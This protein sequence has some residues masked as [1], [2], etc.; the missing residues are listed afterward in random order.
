MVKHL[1]MVQNKTK[2]QQKFLKLKK[3]KLQG[4]R[5]RQQQAGNLKRK[6]DSRKQQSSNRTTSTSHHHKSCHVTKPQPDCVQCT[7]R[8]RVLRGGRAALFTSGA[9]RHAAAVIRPPGGDRRP[10]QWPQLPPPRCP[11]PT[12]S[13]ESCQS[14]TPCLTPWHR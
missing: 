6:T 1:T 4:T 2:Q 11:R 14:E 12:S 13:Y 9:F 7:E 5:T 8:R 10:R 3:K